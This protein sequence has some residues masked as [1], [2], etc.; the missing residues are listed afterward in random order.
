MPFIHTHTHTPHTHTH[1]HTHTRV[2]LH[3]K[4][5]V[6]CVRVSLGLGLGKAVPRST[7]RKTSRLWWVLCSAHARFHT[8]ARIQMYRKTQTCMHRNIFR[9]Y[10]LHRCEKARKKWSYKNTD[11]N[12]IFIMNYNS[13]EFQI[14]KFQK[15]N[16]RRVLRCILRSLTLEGFSLSSTIVLKTVLPWHCKFMSSVIYFSSWFIKLRLEK[17]SML[18]CQLLSKFELAQRIKKLLGQF[19]S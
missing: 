7:G 11:E 12:E 5:H 15:H 19:L 14:F 18:K 8:Q 16:V 6:Y 10:C 2:T 9:E 1:T 3:C 13:L 17:A 4:L